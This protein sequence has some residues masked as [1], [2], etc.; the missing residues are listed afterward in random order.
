M[1]RPLSAADRERSCGNKDTF[2]DESEARAHM[3]MNG[4][5]SMLRTYEC[6]YCGFL[7]LTSRKE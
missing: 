7:H 4:T 3:L 6:R 5:A 1:D 2:R